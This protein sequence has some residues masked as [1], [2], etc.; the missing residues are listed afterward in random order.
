MLTSLAIFAATGALAGFLAGLLGI[1]G[2][3]ILVPALIFSFQA[4]GVSSEVLTHLAVGTSLAS[5]VLTSLSSLRTHHAQ[6]GVD[7]QLFKQLTIGLVLGALIGAQIA[8][9]LPARTLQFI[10]GFFAIWT[11]LKMFIGSKPVGTTPQVASTRELHAVGGFIGVASAIFGIGGGSLMV[12]YLVKSGVAMRR[13]VG[14]AA[15]CGFPI[16]VA[17]V[18]GFMY[19]GWGLA[20]L[21]AGSTGYV[22]W[23]ALAGIA[24]TSLFAAHAG[25]LM[26]HRMPAQQLKRAFAV[27]LVLVGLRF[28]VGI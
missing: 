15:A 28:L 11:G 1:G 4:Q 8:H 6:G 22:Y 27:L 18:I 5:I 20:E 2:G 24:L 3:M 9:A 25:A 16:A 10:I 7:L 14:T 23:P 19:S 12:P 13:A 17:G 26:A 21:P